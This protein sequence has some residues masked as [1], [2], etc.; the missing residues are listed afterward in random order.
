MLKCV[1]N[2]TL[3]INSVTAWGL[4]VLTFATWKFIRN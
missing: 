2:V 3:S 4:K 1:N